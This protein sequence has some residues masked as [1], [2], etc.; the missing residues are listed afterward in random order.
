M[1]QT[2]PIHSIYEDHGIIEPSSQSA[3]YEIK[4]I[5]Y[6]LKW[7]EDSINGGLTNN[8]LEE[9]VRNLEGVNSVFHTMAYRRHD[10]YID[11]LHFKPKTKN[12][13][14]IKTIHNKNERHR[15]KAL[16]KKYRC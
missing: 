7:C 16:K 1:S 3:M 14:K 12:G 13:R 6:R 11:S 8:N 2:I 10:D 4:K 5:L 9:R 15:V